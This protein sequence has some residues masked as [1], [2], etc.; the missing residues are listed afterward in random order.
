MRHSLPDPLRGR[1]V[2][3]LEVARQERNYLNRCD[4]RL[5]SSP[6]SSERLIGLPEN[7]DLAERVDA[8]VARFGR[9]QDTVGDK[10]LPAFLRA[11]GERPGAFLENLDRAEKLGLLDSADKWM[12]SRR[13]RNRMIHEYVSDLNELA[14]ALTAAHQSIPLLTDTFDHIRHRLY[15]QYPELS[16]AGGPGA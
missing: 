4:A 2:H 1:L 11:M 8:F 6:M 16:D 9:F 15:R 7:D 10:L 14:T 13:L 12:A 5:F 3:L